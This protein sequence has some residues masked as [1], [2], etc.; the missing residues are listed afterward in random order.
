ML[1]DA[2]DAAEQSRQ[3]AVKNVDEMRKILQKAEEYEQTEQRVKKAEATMRPATQPWFEQGDLLRS[4]EEL[5]RQ[6]A[7]EA[8][9]LE[10]LREQIRQAE[11]RRDKLTPGN[12]K[13]G[14]RP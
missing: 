8:S 9:K 10:S 14:P 7:A 1:H 5:K 11:E 6:Q 3:E 4:I 13:G 2:R 12:G